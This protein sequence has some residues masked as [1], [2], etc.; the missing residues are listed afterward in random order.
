[1]RHSTVPSFRTHAAR[2]LL[3]LSVAALALTGCSATPAGTDSDGG[4]AKS[5]KELNIAYLSF[6]VA[7]SYDAPMLAAAQ[8]VAADNNAKITVFDANND[9]QAQFSQLQNV[10][11]S[12]KYDGIITQPIFGTGLVDLVTQAIDQ[13]IKVVN[14]NQILGPDFTTNKP[15][16]KG[17]SANVTFVPTDIGKKIGEQVVAACASQKLDPCT[18]GYLY[19]IKA[20]VLD[21]AIRD[22]FNEAIKGSPVK[23]IAEGE[24]FFTATVALGAVQDM[25]QAHPDVNLIA[26]S[27]QG[28]QGAVQALDAAGKTGKVLLVGFG[29]SSVGTQAVAAGK[30]FSTVAMTPASEGRLGMKALIKALRT[31]KDSGAI[32]PTDGIPNKGVIDKS[33]AS[34][35]TAEWV[36]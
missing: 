19:D 8:A 35:F 26:G 12:G 18:V 25:L 34:S 16:I 7:N 14:I 5:N 13:G 22:G 32:D 11:T 28:I 27:D 24:S 31:G 30:W 10:I 3:T 36:G 33:V 23:V 9:P 20:S 21:V 15:Q 4:G 1:M 2:A 6:A 17:L 29:A